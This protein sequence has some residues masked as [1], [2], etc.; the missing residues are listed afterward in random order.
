MKEYIKTQVTQGHV[1]HVL[2]TMPS[3]L[4]NCIV[5]SPPY[6]GLRDYNMPPVAW[7]AFEFIPMPGLPPVK[8]EAMDCCLGL[9]PDPLSFVGHMVL[10]FREAR[11][12]LKNDG[13]AWVNFGDSYAGSW[14]NYG[15]KNRGS[16][17]QREITKGSKVHNKGYDNMDKTIPP[18]AKKM[19]CIKPKDLLGIPWRIAFALQADGWYLRQDVIWNK[20]NPMPE[21]VTDRCTKAHEYIFMLTKSK[22]YFFNQ[23]AIKEP[24]KMSS[25]VR[26]DQKI[27]D[28]KGSNRVPGKTNG[29]MKAVAPKSWKGSF[30][31]KGKTGEMQ[32]TRGGTRKSGNKERKNGVDRGCPEGSGSNVCENVPWEGDFANKKSVWTITTKPNKEA[33]FAV[34]PPEIPELCIKAGCPPHGVVMDLFDGSGTTREVANRMGLTYYSIEINPEYIAISNKRNERFINELF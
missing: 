12:V 28:Q 29:N 7:P 33:H 34:F 8:I 9:E 27:E 23:D 11:R 13:I 1:L 24:I 10:I 19:E 6:Y 5:T 21:S 25:V 31:D 17:E 20:P 16:G 2:Q 15:G 26:L 30:F 18:T 3:E 14:G 4:V 32:E 22:K